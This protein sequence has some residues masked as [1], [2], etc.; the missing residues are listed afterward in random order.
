MLTSEQERERQEIIDLLS[1]IHLGH[2]TDVHTLCGDT[3]HNFDTAHPRF[4]EV[5]SLQPRLFQFCPELR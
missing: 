5:P 2:A 4:K 3:F 1:E